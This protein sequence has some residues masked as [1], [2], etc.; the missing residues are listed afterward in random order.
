[1]SSEVQMTPSSSKDLEFAEAMKAESDNNPYY[2]PQE[3]GGY[4]DRFDV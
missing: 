3:I 1:M 2:G 4:F